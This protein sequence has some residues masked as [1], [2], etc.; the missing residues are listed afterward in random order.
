ML[1]HHYRKTPYLECPH[2][3]HVQITIGQRKKML[4]PAAVRQTCQN[5]GTNYRNSTRYEFSNFALTVFPLIGLTFLFADFHNRLPLWIILAIIF[6]I[7]L[8]IRHTLL[9]LLTYLSPFVIDKG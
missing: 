9:L 6:T 8:A 2:C 4:S 1:L 7:T 3:G 5:C